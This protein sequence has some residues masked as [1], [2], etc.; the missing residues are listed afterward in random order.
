MQDA[1]ERNR[2]V[3]LYIFLAAAL[4]S[5]SNLLDLEERRS[6]AIDLFI[7]SVG[8]PVFTRSTAHLKGKRFSIH[9]SIV[10]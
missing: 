2:I 8:D 4:I 6:D 10:I 3:S 5:T 9:G 1:K 7:G